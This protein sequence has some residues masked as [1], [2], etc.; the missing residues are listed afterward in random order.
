[1]S[2]FTSSQVAPL[3]LTTKGDLVV[4]NGTLPVRLAVGTD[5]YYLQADSSAPSGLVWAAVSGGSGDDF[6]ACWYNIINSQTVTIIS[7]KQMTVFGEFTLDG[8]LNIEGQLI[9]ED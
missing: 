9:L 8:V 6:H 3:P 4:H 2:N 5:M 1:M 7:R